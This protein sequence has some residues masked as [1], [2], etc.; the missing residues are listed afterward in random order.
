MKLKFLTTILY[1]ILLL[2]M[3]DF[4]HFGNHAF[5]RDWSK[6]AKLIILTHARHNEIAFEAPDKHSMVHSE[7]CS[8]CSKIYNF[9][10]LLPIIT[11][12][13]FLA[14]S[15]VNFS[16]STQNISIFHFCIF[17]ARAPPYML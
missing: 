15:A 16:A 5:G 13:T 17:A 11:L 7:S 2:S 1:S 14:V 3:V 10:A 12:I 9:Q 8:Y 6:A 4:F